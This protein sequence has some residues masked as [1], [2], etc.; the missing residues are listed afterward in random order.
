MTGAFWIDT[1]ISLFISLI[2]G[3]IG[4]VVTVLTIKAI[5]AAFYRKI[6]LEEEIKRGNIAA[7]IFA[8]ALLLFAA[9]IIGNALS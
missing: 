2:F 1:V 8:S 6:D 7:A 5:D 4:L 9:I 3:L